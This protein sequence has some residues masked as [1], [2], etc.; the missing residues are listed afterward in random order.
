MLQLLL[1][2][3]AAAVVVVVMVVVVWLALPLSRMSCRCRAA[4]PSLRPQAAA[5][6]TRLARVVRWLSRLVSLETS[7]CPHPPGSVSVLLA[8]LLSALAAP[9][10]ACRL[11]G[12]SA[13]L[14]WA[15][16]RQVVTVAFV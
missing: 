16:L 12:P 1:L 5:E 3:A 2:L 13:L 10:A 4:R 8:F 9:A 7:P 11:D 15:T 14:L 6:S